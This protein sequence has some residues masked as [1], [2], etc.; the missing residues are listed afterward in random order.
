MITILKPAQAASALQ[1]DRARIDGACASGALEAV[2][3]TPESQKRSWRIE[4]AALLDWYRRGC[5]AKPEPA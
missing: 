3:L 1:I 5:P 4:E 2:D